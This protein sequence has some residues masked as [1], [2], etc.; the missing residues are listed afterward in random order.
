MSLSAEPEGGTAA[1][2]SGICRGSCGKEPV[3]RREMAV[4]DRA[5]AVV[6]SPLPP[7][8]YAAPGGAERMAVPASH[9]A[10]R[11]TASVFA[12]RR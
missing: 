3:A 2:P 8:R 9:A 12:T 10:H 5:A 4:G 6:R 7:G 11:P 1:F